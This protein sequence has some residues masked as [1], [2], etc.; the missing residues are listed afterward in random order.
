MTNTA[1]RNGEKAVFT[2]R[3]LYKKYG[4]LPYKMSK[5]EEYELYSKNKD[6][7][8]SDK[9][10]TFNDTNGKL[11]ALKPDVTLS[12]IKNA[13]ECTGVKNKVYYNENVYRVSE[14]THQFKEIMQ[15]GL[16]CIGDI[17]LYD[18]YE[19]VLLAAKSLECIDE[20]FILDI[21]NLDILESVLNSISSDVKFKNEIL[22]CIKEKNTHDIE[23]ICNENKIS[24]SDTKRLASL[25]SLY[26]KLSDI[27]PSL[28][29]LC[30]DETARSALSEIKELYSMLS[31]SG[32]EDKI[33]FDFSIVSNMKYYSGIVFA[34][35]I[36]GI[37]S[38]VL[39][40]GRYDRLI[41]RMGRRF[42]A[43]GFA[44]YLDLLEE[45]NRSESDYD[46]D[47][48]LLYNDSVK[49]EAIKDAVN[50]LTSEG[51]SVCAQKN[52]P[53]QLR[54]KETICLWEAEK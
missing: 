33:Y 42:G 20:D 52:T 17:D 16:E 21:S 12:I 15:T 31:G 30:K 47:V 18:I 45:L 29:P 34:G 38:S 48:L 13:E 3:S 35:F 8:V 27:I 28:E 36:G 25:S 51:K 10:I 54:A 37:C 44:I 32:Y 53:Q 1:E 5:F 2:L 11:M 23:R 49:A 43:V 41:R 24:G 7:L 6:F 26:G 9:V 50:K 40:G 4:Y 39:S 14:D 46:I 22:G 19:A